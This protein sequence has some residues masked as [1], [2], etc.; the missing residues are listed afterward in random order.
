MRDRKGTAMME[1]QR[2]LQLDLLSHVHWDPAWYSSF[3]EYRIRLV[4][5]VR[6]LL[7]TLENDPTY[8]HF[9]F[10][11]QVSALE[12]YL[13]L[14]PG[15]EERIRRQVRAGRLAIGP[16]YL[17][18]EE[19]MISA[20]SH[21]RNLLWGRRRGTGFGGV[22]TTS[23]LCDMV[24]HIPQMPQI[25]AGFG[26]DSFCA[27]RGIIDGRELTKSEFIWEGPDGTRLLFKV[28][29]TCYNSGPYPDDP[30]RFAA[31]VD[32][33]AS[34]LAPYAT[35][36]HLLVMQGGDHMEALPQTPELIRQYNRRAGREALRQVSLR[37]H[38]DAVRS[39]APELEVHRG[40]LRS[41]YQS[42][43]LTGILSA[44]M[45]LKLR[46]ELLVRALERWVEPFCL[47]AGQLGHGYQRELV[48]HAWKKQLKNA[49]HDCIYGAHDDK[50]TPDIVN[51][52]KRGLEVAQWLTGDALHA[53]ASRIDTRGT[54]SVV[55]VFNPGARSRDTVVAEVSI[56][57]PEGEPPHPEW[58]AALP[59]GTPVPVH[60]LGAERVENYADF[61]GNIPEYVKQGPM[62]HRYALA[63]LVP[64]VPA[65]GWI[66]LAMEQV[67]WEDR[68]A[69]ARYLVVQRGLAERSGMTVRPDRGENDRLRI[70]FRHDGSLDVE[71]KSTGRWYRGLHVF[72]DAPDL[73]DLYNFV[74]APGDPVVSSRGG[75]ARLEIAERGP[76]R[77]TW[78]VSLELP[79][80]RPG[81][82]STVVRSAVTMK[83]GSSTLEFRSTI[84]NRTGDHR[85][86]VVFP[87]GIACREVATG[88]QFHV[89]ARP[90][91]PEPLPS[92]DELPQGNAPHRLFID[93][94]DGTAG[95]AFLDRG[96]PEYQAGDDG[97][98]AVTLLRSSGLLSHQRSSIRSYQPAGP[99][100]P[101]PAAQEI[102]THQ[103]D[104][105]LYFHAGDWT[106]GVQDALDEF[107]APVRCVPGDEHPG[108][109]P[110]AGS[111]LEVAG[112]GVVFSTLKMAEEGEQVVLRVYNDRG[113]PVSGEVRML[114]PIAEAWKATLAEEARQQL[115]P[116]GNRLAVALGPHEIL[117]V[118]LRLAE[119]PH[120]EPA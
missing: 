100:I 43:I 53:I 62:G 6:R 27:W 104:Y 31:K 20:E 37:Q 30:D 1:G 91:S 75:P 19:S 83:P 23:Y 39:A 12:D 17:Q 67:R 29:P 33:L 90:T 111:F 86:R 44:R 66:T 73:G 18:P 47:I 10:D 61:S 59:D 54:S 98:L 80:V 94:S 50:V 38:L 106:G 77:C 42:F 55:T 69:R 52:Y 21:V 76:V 120:M 68:A 45:H 7:D 79:P 112:E 46:N 74:P 40:E 102:G 4:R 22:M 72:E 110:R 85:L 48:R 114:R 117:T 35:T 118:L 25:V 92:Y 24:G 28:M 32:G 105:A 60:V 11:G 49:F 63:I 51:D 9:M 71:D 93:L 57:V 41:T 26:C 8:T 99:M 115:A 5:L 103:V 119:A 15:D 89:L 95:I 58:I 78:S 3:E 64:Q 36:S 2:G 113:L 87:T 107:Y 82:P 108:S 88:S 116:A 34:E 65:M 70:S 101:T 56:F 16:W 109:L 84:E 13:E 96:L 81:A 14:V 97:E